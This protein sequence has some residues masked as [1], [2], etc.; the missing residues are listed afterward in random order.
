MQKDLKKIKSNNIK[1]V[2]Y[3]KAQK[4]LDVVFINKN[5][6]RYHK[7]PEEIYKGLLEAESAGKYFYAKIRDSFAYK[8]VN[9]KKK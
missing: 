6:Y 2:F 5:H 9:D 7:V 4:T 1:G 3:D 8:Q